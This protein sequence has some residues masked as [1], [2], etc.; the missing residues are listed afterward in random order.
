[1]SIP[2]RRKSD[3]LQLWDLAYFLVIA[4]TE[5]LIGA[6]CR[7]LAP[8]CPALTLY[9]QAQKWDDASHW[10][11]ERYDMYVYLLMAALLFSPNG[12]ARPQA[13][14]VNVKVR[15]LL[16]DKDLNQKPVPFYVINL[17]NTASSDAAAELKTDLDG[18]AERQLAPGHYSISTPKPVELGGKRYTW[19]LEIQISGTEQHLDL[20]NDN[21]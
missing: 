16:V 8:R 14:P 7:H 9:P 20:T 19:N 13:A 12:G 4:D 10:P 5:N 1:L 21:A 2:E 15:V 18:K 17:R 6:G 3:D 11:Q